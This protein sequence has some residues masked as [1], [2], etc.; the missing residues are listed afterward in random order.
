M[1]LIIA[2]LTIED[3]LNNI[4]STLSY[5]ELIDLGHTLSKRPDNMFTKLTLLEIE[6]RQDT[7]TGLEEDFVNDEITLFDRFGKSC[8]QYFNMMRRLYL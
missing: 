4:L 7:I 1:P 2:P 5:T 3:Q 6:I 8:E